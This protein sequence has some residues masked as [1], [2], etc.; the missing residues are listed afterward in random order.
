MRGHVDGLASPHELGPSLP[1][2]YLEDS[3]AQRF[4]SAFDDVMAP[5]HASLDNLDAYVDP[6]LA[7]EDFVDWLA[8]WV[9]AVIDQTWDSERRRASVAYAAELYRLRGTSRG[10]AA[11]VELV[12]GGAVEI[13]ENGATSWT[14]DPTEGLPGTADQRLTVR[15]TVPDPKAVDMGRLDRLVRAAKPAHVPHTIEVLPTGGAAAAPS[16]DGKG[17]KKSKDPEGEPPTEPVQ[18]G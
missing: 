11:Q 7:P 8:E 13:V 5:I 4:T 2:L 17:P 1:G 10:L 12:T 18:A 15:V 9:G 16:R 14:L 3:F 6:W